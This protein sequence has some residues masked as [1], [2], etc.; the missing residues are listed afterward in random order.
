MKM[1]TKMALI[2]AIVLSMGAL[3]A[4]QSTNAP[5]DNK[6]SRMMKEHHSEQARKLT[7]EQQEAFQAKRAEQRQFLA[8]VKKACDGK[9][10]GTAVQLKT[11]EQTIS[12]TC[13]MSFKAD[14]KAMKQEMQKAHAEHKP[15][16]GEHRP[17]QGEMRGHMQ[18]GEVLTDAQRAEMVK[19]FDQRLAQ[20]QAQQQAIAQACQGKANGSAVQIKAGER[21]IDGKCEVRFKPAAP[22]KA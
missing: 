2:S 9:A 21:T 20:R 19:Q 5:Q 4:C 14:R 1:M 16:R 13:T 22:A 10:A 6:H 18:R 3:T 8:D 11:G 15:M 12:G 17:M 7:P